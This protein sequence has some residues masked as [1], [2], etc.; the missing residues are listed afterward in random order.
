MGSAD[1]M[2][3]NLHRRIEVLFPLHAQRHKEEIQHLIALQLADN[4]QAV[5][6]DKEGEMQPVP[7]AADE[8]PVQSQQAIYNY[9]KGAPGA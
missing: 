8:P 2:D 6:L 1:L 5:A 3:R 9:L 4:T 7:L